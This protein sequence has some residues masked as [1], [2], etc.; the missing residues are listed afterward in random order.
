MDPGVEYSG[1]SDNKGFILSC[2]SNLD[3]KD[4]EPAEPNQN[5]DSSYSENIQGQSGQ[6]DAGDRRQALN[7]GSKT[8]TTY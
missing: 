2:G 5:K 1:L 6:R 7:T 3:R 8:L 4:N